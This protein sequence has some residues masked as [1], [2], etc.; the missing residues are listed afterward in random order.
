MPLS[1]DPSRY[2]ISR[3]QVSADE[4]AEAERLYQRQRKQESRFLTWARQR[5]LTAAQARAFLARQRASLERQ[6]QRETAMAGS[7]RGEAQLLCC[8]RWWPITQTPLRC[9]ACGT[10]YLAFHPQRLAAS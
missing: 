6:V 9:L 8:G 3:G 2:G 10:V 5:G 4:Q 7:L 1:K